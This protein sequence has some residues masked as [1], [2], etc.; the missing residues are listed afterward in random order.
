MHS[1][2]QERVTALRHGRE[3]QA[4][5]LVLRL[6]LRPL[7]FW[8]VW[9]YSLCCPFFSL[10]YSK[11]ITTL[12]FDIN[13]FCIKTNIFVHIYLYYLN[14]SWLKKSNIRKCFWSSDVVNGRSQETK[15]VA[16]QKFSLLFFFP[17]VFLFSHPFHVK[18]AKIKKKMKKLVYFL[19]WNIWLL[20]VFFVWERVL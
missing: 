14:T 19:M 8:E 12:P 16:T 7:C 4:E 13:P 2:Q 11:L 3:L 18:L 17:T 9:K 6:G 10:S 1:G 15:N 5:A 20:H